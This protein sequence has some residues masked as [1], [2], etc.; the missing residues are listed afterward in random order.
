[1]ILC[2]AVWALLTNDVDMALAIGTVGAYKGV[3]GGHDEI[4]LVAEAF[5]GDVDGGMSAIAEESGFSESCEGDDGGEKLHVGG[6]SSILDG[7]RK[8]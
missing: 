4:V 1:M 5:D 6:L 7:G 3:P 8:E 2:V